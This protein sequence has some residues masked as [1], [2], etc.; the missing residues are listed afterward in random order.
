L[1]L[2]ELTL[3]AYQ[4]PISIAKVDSEEAKVSVGHYIA[5]GNLRSVFDEMKRTGISP[6]PSNVDFIMRRDLDLDQNALY[7]CKRLDE[8]R[9][10]DLKNRET[11]F[12]STLHSPIRIN[13]FTYDQSKAQAPNELRKEMIKQLDENQNR[14]NNSI[15]RKILLTCLAGGGTLGAFG[16]YLGAL[17][18]RVNMCS[19]PPSDIIMPSNYTTACYF[20]TPFISGMVGLILGLGVF[21]ATLGL[22]KYIKNDILFSN[23]RGEIIDTNNLEVSEHPELRDIFR[24]LETAADPEIKTP[25]N[26]EFYKVCREVQRRLSERVGTRVEVDRYAL[27][28]YSEKVRNWNNKLREK[29]NIKFLE[30]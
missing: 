20:A 7:K 16:G 18:G 15:Y 9:F 26:P 8:T 28:L 21:S 11:P 4:C 30:K 24:A 2:E 17:S 1:P 19:I 25:E 6:Y 10:Y 22:G 14:I 5:F 12:H 13:F 27:K 23:I 3:T 29:A